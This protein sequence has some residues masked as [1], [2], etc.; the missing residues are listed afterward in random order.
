MVTQLYGLFSFIANLQSFLHGLLFDSIVD[1]DATYTIDG[2][3]AAVAVTGDLFVESP[4]T[5]H[6]E[7]QAQF[8]GIDTAND[9]VFVSEAYESGKVANGSAINLTSA[10]WTHGLQTG[11]PIL[12]V[13]G[14]KFFQEVNGT[15]YPFN[16]KSYR[17]ASV[18]NLAG[19]PV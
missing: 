16:N 12:V 13:M 11:D 1:Y 17:A 9:I 8:V 18:V 14:V 4:G 2:T 10:T 19:V 7:V 5:T 3:S 15:F 6:H